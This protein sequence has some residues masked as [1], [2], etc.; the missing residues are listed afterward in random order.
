MTDTALNAQEIA[1]YL[2]KNPQFFEQHADVFIALRVPHPQ[3]NQVISLGERQILRL[4]EQLRDLE[5]RL[6]ELTHHAHANEVSNAKV[7]DWCS[8][9]LSEADPRQLPSEITLG[10]ADQLRLEHVGLR[11][12]NLAIQADADYSAAVSQDIRDFTDSMTA[13]Y[14]GADTAFEAVQW[15]KNKP[16]SLALIPLRLDTEQPSIGLL[17]LGSDDPS[18]FHPA[19]GTIFLEAIGRLASAALR[20]LAM[21]APQ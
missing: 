16:Q 17:V 7:L 1:R 11:L 12:W 3:S 4:R 8:R 5:T 19:M 14:C 6:N 18:R 10:L 13:P 21:P 9:L 15:L 20:R 2:K